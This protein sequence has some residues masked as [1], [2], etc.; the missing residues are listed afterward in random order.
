MKKVTLSLLIILFSYSGLYPQSQP[1]QIY[2]PPLLLENSDWSNG[3]F[4]VSATQP[5][6]RPS[7]IYRASNT[8]LYVAVPDTSIVSGK[9]LAILR[10][11]NN[12]VSWVVQASYAGT[13][14]DIR[15]TK[16]VDAGNDSLY[17]FYNIGSTV[18]VYNFISGNF[19]TF[20]TYTNIRDWD[21]TASSTHAIYL[22]VD[23]LGNN[24]IRM[25]GSVNG[26]VSWGFSNYVSSSGAFPRISMSGTGD[27]C[28]LNYYATLT[29]DTG[30]SLIR[31][32]KWRE[33]TS[34]TLVSMGYTDPVAAG[35]FK[36]QF[37]TV[38]YGGKAW[39]FYTTGT[40]GNINLN[41]IQSNDNGGTYG[42]PFTIGS[43]TSRD[44]YWFDAKYFKFG[45]GGVDLI[46]YSDTAQTGVP[47]NLTDRLYYSTIGSGSP[48]S[49][50]APVQI[51]EHWPFW[52]SRLFIP[53]LIEFYNTSGDAGAIWVGGPSPYKLY[54][55]RGL[56]ITRIKND[57]NSIAEKYS[58][59]QNYPNPFNPVTQ[60]EFSV[61]KSGNVSLIVYDLLGREVQ[62]LINK[63]MTQGNYSVGFDGTHLTSGTYFYKMTSGDFTQT[64]KM[65][66]IK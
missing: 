5:F 56:S 55:D 50:S 3:D 65:I 41:C 13:A 59:S 19:N 9:C 39:L 20:S 4:I 51:S 34:G 47:T 37:Q 63:N 57:I 21:A 61:P 11:S 42:T 32:F 12:G 48:V 66:L 23:L 25:F 40:T 16:I 14:T 6:G 17:L 24:D 53:S 28:V 8:S 36:D 22:V 58:L 64:K 33:S 45:A 10:S 52:S 54:F 46:W 62:T 26:G 15:K 31:N 29:A 27:T 43:L 18:Y 60:I 44:E 38:V 7:G 2:D 35:V 1:F 49:Y 30:S